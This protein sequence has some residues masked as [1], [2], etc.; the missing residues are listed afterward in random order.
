MAGRKIHILK[1]ISFQYTILN[2]ISGVI[3][4]VMKNTCIFPVLACL[5]LVSMLTACNSSNQESSIKTTTNDSTPTKTPLPPIQVKLS[6]SEAPPLDTPADITCTIK[7]SPH[8]P[9]MVNTTAEITLPEGTAFVS[10]DLTWSGDLKPD[11]TVTF[12]GVIVFDTTGHKTIE[13]YVKHRINENDWVGGMDSIYLDIG[14]NQS[15]FGW[16][17]VPVPVT[18]YTGP[19]VRVELSLSHLPKLNEPTELTC[20]VISDTEMSN[21]IV[22]MILPEWVGVEVTSGSPE[23]QGDLVAGVP[24]SY[25]I[26]IVFR[27]YNA[28]SFGW[29][30]HQV[31]TDFS[32]ANRE[33]LCLRG[34]EE[35][36]SYCPELTPIP[37]PPP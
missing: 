10:G 7:L 19:N 20:T 27:S 35:G 11:E 15:R 13:A 1:K 31:G 25:S 17:V 33:A 21:V 16:E 37:P 30:I 29:H 8:V 12:S 5:L 26:E 3:I 18:M 32:Y 14:T 28:R 6:M 24:V 2:W 23:W 9:A 34:T 4:S 36:Y 22:T